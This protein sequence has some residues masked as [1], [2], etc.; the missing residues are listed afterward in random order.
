MPSSQGAPQGR[1]STSSA[2]D[3]HPP[4]HAFAA[5]LWVT[6]SMFFLAAIAGLVRYCT[7]QGYDP[8]QILFLRTVFSVL[9]MTP[10]V[11]RRG[12]SLVETDQIQLYGTRI[13]LSFVSMQAM[14]HALELITVGEVTAIGFLSPIFGT[15]F[16]IFI[17]AERVRARRW[18]A[19]GFGFLGAIIILRPGLVSFG[20]GQ[21]LALVSAM[22]IGVI[23]PLVKKLTRRDDPDRIVFITNL[24]MIPLAIVPALLVWRWPT[25][26]IWLALAALGLVAVLGHATL[27]RGYA[28]T[29]ASLVMTYKFSRLPFAVLVGYLA[30]GEVIDGPVWIGAIIIFAAA[31]YITHREVQLGR[32]TKPPGSV[33]PISPSA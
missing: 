11:M 26:E 32:N 31:V 9:W 22:A 5:F 2:A 15:L 23:G 4:N 8:F 7:K 33:D 29:D 25:G 6:L 3:A 18:A 12:W 13:L 10:L 27:V 30:F 21:A 17:L 16:A 24:G 14:F 19:L 28:L 20:A 1:V